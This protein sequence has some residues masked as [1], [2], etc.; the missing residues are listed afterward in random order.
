[1][2]K[3]RDIQIE[4][5]P[6]GRASVPPRDRAGFTLTELMIVLTIIGIIAAFITKAGIDGV[7]RANEADTLSLIQKLDAAMSERMEA[8]LSVSLDPNNS[9]LILAQIYSST[10]PGVHA[11]PERAQ[12]IALHDFIKAEVPDVFFLSGNADYPLNFAAQ[13][14]PGDVDSRA[15]YS[16]TYA[17]YI[18]P[19]GAGIESVSTFG[20]TGLVYGS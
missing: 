15:L 9:H 16:Q 11:G 14:Y 20:S 13:S 10:T 12:A 18:L 7:R 6:G 4:D 19:L 2:K 5:R 1:M 8:L 3:P 17:S